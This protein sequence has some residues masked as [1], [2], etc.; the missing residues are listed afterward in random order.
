MR[1]SIPRLL[2]VGAAGLFLTGCFYSREIDRMRHSIE[3][4]IP[5]AEFRQTVVVTLGPVGLQ[6]ARWVVG[7]VEDAD[8]Q[9]A[10]EYL[11]HVQRV[12]VG[13]YKTEY[14]PGL[15]EVRLPRQVRRALERDGWEMAVRVKEEGNLVWVFYREQKGVVRDLFVTIVSDEEMVLVR[16]KGRLDRILQ[17]A[18]DDYG[19][20]LQA[21]AR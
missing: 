10:R 9:T 11:K 20:E 15:E 3:H 7:L 16:F 8:A 6:F 13:V 5:G 19:P 17:K 2:A 21:R 18:I 4:E 14:L 12:K 1:R